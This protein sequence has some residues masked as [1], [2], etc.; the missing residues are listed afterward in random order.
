M[1]RLS[2]PASRHSRSAIEADDLPL[3]RT[4]VLYSAAIADSFGECPSRS[5]AYADIFEITEVPA[6][7]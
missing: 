5:Y 1:V 6:H 4:V 7:A 3:M 2:T